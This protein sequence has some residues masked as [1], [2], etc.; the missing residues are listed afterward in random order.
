MGK[1]ID[2]MNWL[3]EKMVSGAN[4]ILDIIRPLTGKLGFDLPELSW[5]DSI[6][7]TPLTMEE[8]WNS[9]WIEIGERKKNRATPAIK[10]ALKQLVENAEMTA[11]DFNTALGIIGLGVEDFS[12]TID[13]VMAKH[14]M[15]KK[16]EILSDEETEKTASNFKRL[17]TQLGMFRQSSDATFIAAQRGLGQF[18]TKLG[19][20][21]TFWENVRNAGVHITE[22]FKRGWD[23]YIKE[24]PSFLYQVEAHAYHM[25]LVIERGLAHDFQIFLREGTF[26]LKNMWTAVKES[27]YD[28][29]SQIFAT[30]V[31]KKI[32]GGAVDYIV[33]LFLG[34]DSGSRGFGKIK[35]DLLE[36]WNDVAK[37]WNNSAIINAIE[38]AVVAIV[39]MV[40]SW[41]EWVTDKAKGMWVGMRR[42]QARHTP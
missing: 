25:G 14:P 36:L 17:N 20:G 18:G 38:R 40:A 22:S 1:V 7:Y 24:L 9:S 8:T 27:W 33:D 30:T 23:N 16:A 12:K 10:A 21:S 31:M 3:G 29:L 42:R 28:T 6:Q 41:I 4:K 19:P 2:F 5:V 34:D 37:A 11:R 39:S 13:T 32:V 15:S 35:K 26:T